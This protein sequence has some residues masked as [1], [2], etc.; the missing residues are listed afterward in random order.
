MS[1]GWSPGPEEAREMKDLFDRL[2][3]RDFFLDAK[4]TRTM[5][6][7]RECMK[8]LYSISFFVHEGRGV[9]ERERERERAKQKEAKKRN[10]RK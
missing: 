3:C 4:P 10:K 2:G 8:I 5:P 6:M 1:V 9:R 7:P